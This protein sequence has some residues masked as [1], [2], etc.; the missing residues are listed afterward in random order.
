M[1]LII[2]NNNLWALTVNV[3]KAS[4]LMQYL[5]I[6]SGRTTR[7][8]CYVLLFCLVPSLCWAIFG[9]TFLCN[10]AKKLWMPQLEGSCRSA[11]TYWLSAAS[12][13]ISL[14]FLV[15]T[16]PMPAVVALRLPRKQKA[17]L[18][19]V[20][21]LGF[22]VCAVSLARLATVLITS[23]RGHL[24][25][26]GIWAI[27]MSTVEANVGIVCA[28]LLALKP[29]VVLFFPTLME[30]SEGELPRHCMQ[31]RTIRNVDGGGYEEEEERGRRR[32]RSVDESTLVTTPTTP[33][34]MKS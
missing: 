19:L 23:S 10:P 7:A 25:E 5:R 18:V 22:S 12:T 34:T 20:F 11:Q 13:D 31:I 24:V 3:T 28:C 26:S 29:L 14:D 15:L 1:A 8:L 16:L 32:W 27:I 9:G 30:E 6:F 33:S 4:I 2:A 21:L 17:T